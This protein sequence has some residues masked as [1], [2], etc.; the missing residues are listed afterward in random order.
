MSWLTNVVDKAAGV[1]SHRDGDFAGS[2]SGFRSKFHFYGGVLPFL[3][4]GCVITQC[5]TQPQI[6]DQERQ[7]FLHV[8]PA[9][10]N[11]LSSARLRILVHAAGRITHGIQHGRPRLG[12]A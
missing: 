8:L 9:G 10:F 1:I 4:D 6:V 12:H 11:D 3:P 7:T 2:F 5:V